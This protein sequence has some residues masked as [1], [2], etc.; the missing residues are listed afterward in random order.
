M[1]SDITLT[2]YGKLHTFI[3]QISSRFKGGMSS[4]GTNSSMKS[5]GYS[6]SGVLLNCSRVGA[7]SASTYWQAEA[8]GTGR[9]LMVARLRSATRRWAVARTRGRT[10]DFFLRR[11][12]RE[13]IGGRAVGVTMGADG[14]RMGVGTI[15]FSSSALMFDIA[16]PNA[17]PSTPFCKKDAIISHLAL[18]SRLLRLGL[19][20]DPA[21]E[22]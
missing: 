20:F 19:R 7:A 10:A 3:P 1:M 13:W 22:R 16:C 21:R 14:N 4:V 9:S 18:S 12:S 8:T 5:T 2:V 11:R 15:S 17:D 6:S